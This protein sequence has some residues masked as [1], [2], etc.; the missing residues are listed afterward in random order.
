[1]LFVVD[2]DEDNEQVE[3]PKCKN[4]IELDQKEELIQEEQKLTVA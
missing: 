4:M 1:M 3:C 2:I